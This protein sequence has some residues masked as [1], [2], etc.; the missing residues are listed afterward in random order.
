MIDDCRNRVGANLEELDGSVS[1]YLGLRAKGPGHM[2]Q[3]AS[4]T[5]R[6]SVHG[7][8]CDNCGC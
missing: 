8:K 6:E 2:N 1:V 3:V 5:A 7:I 4:A